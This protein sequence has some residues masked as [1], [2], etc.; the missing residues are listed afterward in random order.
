MIPP[1][2]SNFLP[3]WVLSLTILSMI[4]VERTGVNFDEKNGG[5][6]VEMPKCELT[7]A[8]I[9]NQEYAWVFHPNDCWQ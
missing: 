9:D 7:G 6:L 3:Q 5:D 4:L 8:H 2:H 1:R